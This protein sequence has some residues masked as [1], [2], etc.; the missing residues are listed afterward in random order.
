MGLDKI[1]KE[2]ITDL[3]DRL[4]END[5]TISLKIV[6]RTNTSVKYSRKKFNFFNRNM[7]SVPEYHSLKSKDIKLLYLPY[8]VIV[9]IGREEVEYDVHECKKKDGGYKLISITSMM[10]TVELVIKF[11]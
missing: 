2:W 5:E 9:N 4:E 7:K 8:R 1:E 11:D 3:S 6:K 10:T